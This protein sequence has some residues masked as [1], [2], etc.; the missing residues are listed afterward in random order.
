MANFRINTYPHTLQDTNSASEA[1]RRDFVLRKRKLRV[2]KS[3]Q[4]NGDKNTKSGTTK[5]DLNSVQGKKIKDK[6]VD[7]DNKD[8][9]KKVGRKKTDKRI[10]SK[11]VLK[12]KREEK[13]GKVFNYIR[14]NF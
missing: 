13:F 14:I 4:Q 12:G 1:L 8:R 6:N 11:N 10:V 9:G 5:K 2:M 3:S 7:K